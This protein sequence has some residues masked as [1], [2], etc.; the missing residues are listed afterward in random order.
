MQRTKYNAVNTLVAAIVSIALLAL[1]YGHLFACP[2]APQSSHTTMAMDH[3]SVGAISMDSVG[4]LPSCQVLDKETE[5]CSALQCDCCT[6]ISLAVPVI[7]INADESRAAAATHYRYVLYNTFLSL[8][9]PPPI[10]I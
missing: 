7:N 2:T 6:V 1:P 8:S 3:Q 9:T 4:D 5:G 10:V